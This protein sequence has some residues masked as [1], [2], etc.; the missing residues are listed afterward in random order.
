MIML[1]GPASLGSYRRTSGTNQSQ[2][3]FFPL[4]ER[5]EVTMWE[6]H[7]NDRGN[8]QRMY[9]IAAIQRCKRAR[10]CLA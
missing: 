3:T 5:L 8:V 4:V 9:V 7:A 1:D 2:R 6:R 10:T